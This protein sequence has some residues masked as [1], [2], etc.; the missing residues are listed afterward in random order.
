[1][2]EK[3]VVQGDSSKDLALLR[4]R[5]HGVFRVVLTSFFNF[6]T[7]TTQILGDKH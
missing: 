5:A 4:S 6:L 3:G 1:M 7:Q 2:Y